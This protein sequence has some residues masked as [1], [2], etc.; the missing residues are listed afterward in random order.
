MNRAPRPRGQ[1][2]FTLLP[3]VLAMTLIAAVAFLL[4]RDNGINAEMIAG[5]ADLDRARYA[6]EAGL[7]AVNYQVQQ[8][9]CGGSFPVAAAPVSNS[10]FG[11]AAYS[12]YADSASGYTLTL[13]ST[14]S[15]NGAA[16]TLT[17]SNVTVFK[18]AMQ[19]T[20]LTAGPGGQDTYV[21]SKSDA[22]N[23]NYGGATTLLLST[24][25]TELLLQFDLSSLPAGSRV[26]PYYS[27]GAL[28]AGATLSLYQNNSSGTSGSIISAYLI[29]RSWV[30]GTGNGSSPANGATWNTYD[31]VNA[32]P[33]PGAGYDTRPL[34]SNTFNP[35]VG[36]QTWDIT[37][38]ALAW[39]GSIYPN[40][41]VWIRTSSGSVSNAK[42]VSSDDTGNIAQHPT[43]ALSYLLPCSAAPSV[44]TVTLGAL[45]DTQLNQGSN[46]SNYGGSTTM[47]ADGTFFSA[48]RPLVMFDTSTIPPG[49][50]LKSATLRLYVSAHSGAT[51]NPKTVSAYRLTQPWFEGTKQGTGTANGATWN[52]Y[53]GFFNWFVAGGTYAATALAMATD[54]ATGN[55]PPL[56]NFT[57]GWLTWDLTALA[58][59]WVDGVTPNYGIILIST[60]GDALRFDTRESAGATVPQLV[61]T[62]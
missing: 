43:V 32:W 11:G 49:T 40:Y 6:A 44:T 42:Y 24:G 8:A 45:Q 51:G 61:V 28:Q 20:T 39:M 50:L 26:I 13:N 1:A 58:Q 29:T 35:A 23:K 31:G 38:A 47:A 2:G 17:R 41:G 60:V 4:N 21:N 7:Q 33:A 3:V 19:T 25:G 48:L 36:W 5:Q 46:S 59:S 27:G 55:S 56:G 52:T 10:N 22:S 34:A 54:P 15:Y 16:V 37:D 9:G 53:N 14:G 18:P 62:Y 30:G 57:T 12:A